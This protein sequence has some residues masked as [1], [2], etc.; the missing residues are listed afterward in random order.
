MK[1]IDVTLDNIKEIMNSDV[2]LLDFWAPWCGP[3][4][5]IAPT[6]EELAGEYNNDSVKICKVNTDE[7]QALAV[8]YGIRSIPTVKIFA[9]GVEV[10]TIMGSKSKDAFKKVIEKAITESKGN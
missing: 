8:E 7:M 4:R 6:I 9:K 3:C 1:A 2:V 10:E 5:M